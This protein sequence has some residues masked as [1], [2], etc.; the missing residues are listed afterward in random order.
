MNKQKKT[1]AFWSFL[2]LRRSPWVKKFLWQIHNR[3]VAPGAFQP[4]VHKL[5]KFKQILI[6][7]FPYYYS[8]PFIQIFLSISLFPYSFILSLLSLT[9]FSPLILSLTLFLYPSLFISIRKLHNFC[10]RRIS[11]RGIFFRLWRNDC[12]V[13]K[14][15]L[16]FY[17]LLYDFRKWIKLYSFCKR[18]F[19]IWSIF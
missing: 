10:K 16:N 19:L 6:P 12:F 5:R 11:M 18:S 17:L 14:W 4:N 3:D 2:E 1:R 13:T 7:L 8:F 15:L 9:F